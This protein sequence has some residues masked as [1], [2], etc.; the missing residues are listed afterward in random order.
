[1]QVTNA[2]VA[3]ERAVY[4]Q[5]VNTMEAAY[6]VKQELMAAWDAAN[7]NASAIAG[8]TDQTWGWAGAMSGVRAEINAIISGLASIGGGVLSNA[9]KG[10]ELTALNAGSSVREAAVARMRY[11]RESEWS[12]REMGAGDGIGGWIEGQLIEMDRFQFEE[13]IRLDDEITAA[14]AS[15]RTTTGGGGAMD[16]QTAA[17]IRQID[18]AAAL[19]E[20]L[21]KV[22]TDPVKKWIDSVP[23]WIEAGQQIEMGA[24]GSLKSALSDMIKTGT[25]DIE[26]LGESILG[27]VADIVSDKA[28]AELANVLGR[29]DTAGLGGVLG[30]LFSS[31]G[32]EATIHTASAAG[33]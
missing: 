21:Q 20:E 27:V 18:A 26:A 28:V 31:Q 13:G 14:R 16:D 6:S 25:F 32:D 30:G 24:I 3:A 23:N 15:A 29:G 5:T 33:R 9:A 10:A 2:R 1:L 11:E 17:M 22:A 7:G 19:N 4:A 8:A 12:A